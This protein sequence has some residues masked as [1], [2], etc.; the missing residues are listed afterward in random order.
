M[1]GFLSHHVLERQFLFNSIQP[2]AVTL[3]LLQSKQA[4]VALST[5]GCMLQPSPP[6]LPPKAAHCLMRLGASDRAFSLLE[7]V[8]G[9]GELK[10]CSCPLNH[11]P[12]RIPVPRAPSQGFWMN[13]LTKSSS[14]LLAVFSGYGSAPGVCH[15]SS[16]SG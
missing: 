6:C 2:S 13:C 14:L 12:S 4:G 1:V 3:N 10:P 11:W 7:I 8:R 16:D 5:G 15:Y 9:E